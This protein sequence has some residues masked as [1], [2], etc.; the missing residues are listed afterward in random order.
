MPLR[1]G[2]LRLAI[3]GSP[4]LEDPE[5]DALVEAVEVFE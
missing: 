4:E 1:G 5:V 3:E 2:V